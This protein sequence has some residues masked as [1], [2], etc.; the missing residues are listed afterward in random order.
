MGAGRGNKEERTVLMEFPVLGGGAPPSAEPLPTL[1]GG[2]KKDKSGRKR[3][4]DKIGGGAERDSGA[5]GY[6]NDS[7]GGGGGVGRD[8]KKKHESRS[9]NGRDRERERDGGLSSIQGPYN[10]HGSPLAA[11]S[12]MYGCGASRRKSSR[13]CRE[14]SRARLS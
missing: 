14:S 4:R 7:S 12:G 6:G 3:G 2:T 8:G 10:G 11:I 1:G 9:K 5:V 13:D